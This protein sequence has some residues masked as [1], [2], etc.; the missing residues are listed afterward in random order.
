MVR[1]KKSKQDMNSPKL[2]FANSVEQF[3]KANT[4]DKQRIARVAMSRAMS[5]YVAGVRA[6][7]LPRAPAWFLPERGRGQAAEV[8][9]KMADYTLVRG[10]S[11]ERTA[12][13][14]SVPMVV[15]EGK[16]K[17]DRDLKPAEIEQI[18]DG[19]RRHGLID[20][21]VDLQVLPWLTPVPVYQDN[22]LMRRKLLDVIAAEAGGEEVDVSSWRPNAQRSEFADSKYKV[23]GA[24]LKLR[25]LTLTVSAA[26][27]SA[28]QIVDGW[29]FDPD[30][31]EV[32]AA[33][34]ADLEGIVAKIARSP[35]VHACA[36]I[37]VHQ[38]ERRSQWMMAHAVA[39][40]FVDIMLANGASPAEC[41]LSLVISYNTR[42]QR[43]IVDLTYSHQ[44]E[45]IGNGK[46]EVW[47]KTPAAVAGLAS[48]VADRVHAA[49]SE[50]G[51]G[52]II[53]DRLSP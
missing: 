21:H 10:Q 16:G 12:V 49:A 40:K 39:S 23:A 26:T 31:S 47:A 20:C 36:P 5:L 24:T 11:G 29:Q 50:G 44:N 33:W 3:C 41:E 30:K 25:F 2:V 14:C 35:R 27:K 46:T 13:L 4:L 9:E 53:I 15:E 48:S 52:T 28:R 45:V 32:V 22:C 42:Y 19:L 43:M 7:N 17:T 18:K 6:V 8:V 34:V 51:I 1:S 37:A 38:A